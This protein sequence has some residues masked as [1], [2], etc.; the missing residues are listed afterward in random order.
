[1]RRVVPIPPPVSEYLVI[2]FSLI[3]SKKLLLIAAVA[4]MLL[5]AT[6]AYGY[7]E[8][9]D[10]WFNSGTLVYDSKNYTIVESYNT[11]DDST[12]TRFPLPD[13]DTFYLTVDVLTFVCAAGPDDSIFVGISTFTGGKEYGTS[14]THEGSGFWSGSGYS[15]NSGETKLFDFGG[16]WASTG[17]DF[18][19]NTRPPTYTASWLV[20]PLGVVTGSGTCSGERTYYED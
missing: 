17:N 6:N 20:N 18:N 3:I 10:G 19:Y 15:D 4:V 7:Y 2:L 8:G 14:G 13:R 16:T 1:M 5:G 11:V 12:Y 9:W